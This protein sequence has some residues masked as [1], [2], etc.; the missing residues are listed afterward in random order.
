MKNWITDHF[1]GKYLFSATPPLD[2]ELTIT[3]AIIFGVII[4]L[5]IIIIAILAKKARR[6]PPYQDL[7]DR[8]A[9]T[10][11]NF[12]I[13]GLMLV[14]FRWQEIPYLSA[15]ILVLILI[16]V[17]LIYLSYT[18][19]FWRRTTVKE[20]IKFKKEKAYRKYLPK[21]QSK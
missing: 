20:I 15:P 18:I 12:G 8:V 1:S 6:I 7:K 21:K 13:I 17:F 19:M 3:L 14:F 9:N 16:I 11:I 4:F 5:G 10:F 2:N